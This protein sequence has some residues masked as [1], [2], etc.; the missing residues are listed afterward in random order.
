MQPPRDIAKKTKKTVKF[1]PGNVVSEHEVPQKRSERMMRDP[2][3]VYRKTETAKSKS[4]GQVSDERLA[5]LKYAHELRKWAA[6]A[7]YK[8]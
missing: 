5:T 2:S 6:A 7:I 3:A 8:R 1:I 4:R